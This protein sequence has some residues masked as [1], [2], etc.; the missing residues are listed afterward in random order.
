MYLLN[1]R[2]TLPEILGRPGC[3]FRLLV[4]EVRLIPANISTRSPG[5]LELIHGNIRG[6]YPLQV[7]LVPGGGFR[8]CLSVSHSFRI[9]QQTDSAWFERADGAACWRRTSRSPLVYL[10]PKDI[11]QCLVSAFTV[12]SYD[13][14]RIKIAD[15]S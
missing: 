3:M 1:L 2:K 4:D 5:L 15:Y 13:V 6:V 7:R 9:L 8:I 14:T 11:N 12:W 10:N